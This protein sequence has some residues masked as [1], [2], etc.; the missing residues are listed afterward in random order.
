MSC[1]SAA[2]SVFVSLTL[3]SSLPLA[4]EDWPGWFGPGRDG[5]WREKDI[6]RELP[7]ELPVRWRQA[8]GEGYAGPAVADGRVFVFD[9]ILE[10]GEKNPE[11]PFKRD[12]VTGKERIWC[13][14]AATGERRW[15]HEY[16]ADYTVS[17]PAGPRATPMVEGER[18]W[19]IGVMGDLRCL[20][21]DDGSLV[22]KKQLVD[23][24]G[25]EINTW[26]YSAAPLIDGERLILTV[27]GASGAGV[28]CFRKSTGEEMWRSLELRDPGYSPPVIYEVGK[29]RQLIIWH[30][31]AVVS[32]DPTTGKLYWEHEF[33]AQSALSVAQPIWDAENRRLLVSSFYNGSRCFE[34]DPE[35]PEVRLLWQ[36]K[37]SSETK[38]DGLHALMCTPAFD[39]GHIYGVGSYGQLRCL[40]AATGERVW[41]SFEATGE[42]RWWNA[43]LIRQGDSWLIANEQGELIRAELTPE[44]YREISRSKLIEPTRKVRR[45][46]TVWSCPA[47][48]GARVYARNDKEIVCVDLRADAKQEKAA[49]GDKAGARSE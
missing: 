44:G 12:K 14:D 36:G 29:T 47:F 45:R 38:T 3:F 25:A 30:P 39:A 11:N 13:L 15:R 33:K 22:W 41:E 8:I 7:A 40:D 26:G 48:S 35:Q 34:L 18:V 32:L 20:K 46:M 9:R 24:F 4:A 2:L 49:K 27:A 10:K 31:T 16:V 6:P 37:S 21:V 17:Y 43:F 23:D 19:C 1:R 28:V 42:G 5:I